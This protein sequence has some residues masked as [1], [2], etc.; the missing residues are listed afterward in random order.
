MNVG[1]KSDL[2]RFS[3]NQTQKTVKIVLK[4]LL[5]L[6]KLTPNTFWIWLDLC[7]L[8]FIEIAAFIPSNIKF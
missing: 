6:L 5:I 3:L 2:N 8:K 7:S 4:S 1:F